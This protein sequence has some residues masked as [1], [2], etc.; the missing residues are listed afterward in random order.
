MVKCDIVKWLQEKNM[1]FLNKVF[2][3]LISQLNYMIFHTI[4]LHAMLFIY[5][6]HGIIMA[7]I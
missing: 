1:K 5:Y 6:Y 2:H 3:N 7:V 4:F